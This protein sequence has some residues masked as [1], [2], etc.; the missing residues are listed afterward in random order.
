MISINKVTILGNITKD[1][2]L[3]AL[4]A[5]GNVCTFSVATNRVF[6]DK[7]GNK[8]EQAEFHNIVVFGKQ[9]ESTAQY[10][11][12]GSEIFIEGRIQTRS[13]EKD[14]ATKYR[15]EIIAENVKFGSSPKNESHDGASKNTVSNGG[16]LVPNDSEEID[17]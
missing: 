5:G 9:A 2:E 12:K 7:D 15:T 13:Y 17:F 4:P 3:K 8:Q 10:M 16:A 1:P 6:K 14:G 11:K